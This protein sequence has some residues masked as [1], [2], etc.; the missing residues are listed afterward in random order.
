MSIEFTSTAFQQ[1][2]TIPKDYTGD[3]RNASPP[4]RWQDPPAG[5]QCFAVVCEDP[6]APRGTFTHWII[7]NLPAEARELREGV[8]HES[9][10]QDGSRQGKNGFGKIGYGGPAPPAGKPHRY[11]FKLYALDQLLS[12]KA[13]ADRTA[14]LAAMKG[15]ILAESQLM[16]MYGR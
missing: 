7:F 3:G 2:E 11:F 4:L 13:G 9:A 12:L 15:H 16:G 14:V 5:T 1:G 6:D 8:Q 10:L